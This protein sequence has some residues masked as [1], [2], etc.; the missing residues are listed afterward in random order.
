MKQ[1]RWYCGVLLFLGAALGCGCRHEN[2]TRNIPAVTGFEVARYMGKWHEIARLPHR[3]ERDVVDAS[4][5]YSLRAD[6]TVNV[7]NSGFR[8]GVPTS[9]EGV[10]R[11]AGQPGVGELEVSFFRPFYGAYRIIHLEPDYSA[12]VVTSDTRDYL[13]ILS[14]RKTMP[15]EQLARYLTMLEAWNFPV[16]LLQYPSGTVAAVNREAPQAR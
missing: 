11:S 16:K 13:W 9:V 6:G 2:S 3:F 7:I 8:N 1:K 12:A 10:A 4:A 5:E 15:K 14:R